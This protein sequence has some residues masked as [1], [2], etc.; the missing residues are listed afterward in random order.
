M[1][2]LNPFYRKNIFSEDEANASSIKKSKISHE[3][4]ESEEHSKQ[5]NDDIK[6]KKNVHKSSIE[7]FFRNSNNQKNSNEVKHANTINTNNECN[8]TEGGFDDAFKDKIDMKRSDKSKP[9]SINDLLKVIEEKK[10]I[11]KHSLAELRET[12]IENLS[13]PKDY[14]PEVWKELPEDLKKEL[15]SNQETSSIN[16][17]SADNSASSSTSAINNHVEAEDDVEDSINNNAEGDVPESN[18]CPEGVDLEVF[19]QLPE[20]IRS[21]LSRTMFNDAGV[22]TP[23]NRAAKKHPLPTNSSGRKTAKG[24]KKEAGPKSQSILNFFSRQK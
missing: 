13:C 20:D 18:D 12:K 11:S 5:Q 10:E 15:I 24:S 23:A 9:E 7:N 1:P 17:I 2:E 22:K 6:I 8:G 16:N 4:S 14:D 3:L 19:K 21:E